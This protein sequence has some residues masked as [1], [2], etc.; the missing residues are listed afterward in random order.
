MNMGLKGIL[1]NVF[2]GV[3]A[4]AFNSSTREDKWISELKGSQGYTGEPV[5]IW[6]MV[7]VCGGQ[8]TTLWS[9]FSLS[10]FMWVQGSGWLKGQYL[11]LVFRA[12]HSL[13]IQYF[14]SIFLFPNAP[15]IYL[16]VFS[17]LSLKKEKWIKTKKSNRQK[18]QTESQKLPPPKQTNI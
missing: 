10:T 16:C 7:P 18:C 15:Q 12:P 14:L 17:S 4:H 5:Y 13:F 6:T 3:I 1:L 2:L 9:C 11:P 8:R